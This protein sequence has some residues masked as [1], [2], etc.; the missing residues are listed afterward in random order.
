MVRADVPQVGNLLRKYL[1]RFDI[2]QMFSKEE[3]IDHWFLSGQ[4]KEENGKRVGQVVWAYVVEVCLAAHYG[5]SKLI[6]LQDPT[7]HLITDLISFYS[8]PST[9]M[10][11]KKYN[12]LEAAYL[13]YYASDVIFSPCGSSDDAATHEIKVKQKLT[14]R[15]NALMGDLLTLAKNVSAKTATTDARADACHAG[16]V[17]CR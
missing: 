9:I 13:Y 7:T 2:Y 12:V 1:A 10:K 6:S 3:E 17:R 15:L 5:S 14:D 8:L 11:H 4:G 16:W